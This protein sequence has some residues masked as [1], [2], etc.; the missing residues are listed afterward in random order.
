MKKL[1][2]KFVCDICLINLNKI[3]EILIT[4]LTRVEKIVLLVW[5]LS[6]FYFYLVKNINNNNFFN[7]NFKRI[8][9]QKQN[10]KQYVVWEI[11]VSLKWYVLCLLI[12]LAFSKLEKIYY[13]N[14]NWKWFEMCEIIEWFFIYLVLIYILLYIDYLS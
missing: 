10:D 12:V 5:D 7:P 8:A 13:M 11:K 14:T 3:D 1:N 6:D 9:K 2:E 4:L